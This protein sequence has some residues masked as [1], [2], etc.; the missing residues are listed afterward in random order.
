ML[1]EVITLKNK[2][3]IEKMHRL[4]DKFYCEE[5]PPGVKNMSNDESSIND[6]KNDLEHQK[7]DMDHIMENLDCMKSDIDKAM[8]RIRYWYGDPL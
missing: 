5:T 3:E 2:K 4:L 8:K 6:E 7:Y 1:K